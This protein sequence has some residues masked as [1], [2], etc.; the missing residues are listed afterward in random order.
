[1]P[2]SGRY[3]AVGLGKKQKSPLA[4]SLLCDLFGKRTKFLIF[5]HIEFAGAKRRQ[6]R[7]TAAVIIRI[8]S[9]LPVKARVLISIKSPLENRSVSRSIIKR[10][11]IL[12]QG[13]AFEVLQPQRL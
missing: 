8:F 3:A 2:E 9:K 4:A 5:F 10:D 13:R 11:A 1:L 7:A 12:Y 6:T